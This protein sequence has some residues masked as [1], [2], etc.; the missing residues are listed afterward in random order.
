MERALALAGRLARA[1]A[2]P[3]DAP[4]GLWEPSGEGELDGHLHGRPSL[5]AALQLR[6]TRPSG[7][8]GSS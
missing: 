1:R 6:G 8:V 3:D 4:N 2:K 5:F 7:G